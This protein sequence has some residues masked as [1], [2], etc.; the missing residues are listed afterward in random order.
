MMKKYTRLNQLN[1]YLGKISDDRLKIHRDPS[2]YF[3]FYQTDS[4][5]E[6]NPR[7]ESPE[8]ISICYISQPSAAHWRWEL[9]TAVEQYDNEEWQRF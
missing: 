7:K 3:W 4:E 5:Y 6:S 8:S 2:G 1:N 9:H